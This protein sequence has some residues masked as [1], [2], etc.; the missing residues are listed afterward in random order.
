MSIHWTGVTDSNGDWD[1]DITIR[2]GGDGEHGRS[3]IDLLL[4]FAA[5]TKINTELDVEMLVSWTSFT[6]CSHQ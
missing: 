4:E 5:R 3:T 2:T 1:E 6:R